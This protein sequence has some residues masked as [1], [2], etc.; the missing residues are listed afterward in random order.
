MRCTRW[1]DNDENS[2]LLLLKTNP[3]NKDY[4][5]LT[6]RSAHR[7]MAAV[8]AP[9]SVAEGVGCARASTPN[10]LMRAISG[11]NHAPKMALVMPTTTFTRRP[12]PRPLVIPVLNQP[13]KVP[14]RMQATTLAC[15]TE[16]PL[17]WWESV[18]QK[19]VLSIGDRKDAGTGSTD[20]QC[21]RSSPRLGL[22]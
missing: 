13:R 15:G 10:L 21:V 11:R 19:A 5:F 2:A 8:I 3:D 17:P 6:K 22:T 9:L 14:T 12:T 16:A 1:G 18:G 4:G 7:A 20:A